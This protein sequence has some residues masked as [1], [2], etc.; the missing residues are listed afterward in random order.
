MASLSP[1]AR[2]ISD[3]PSGLLLEE[4]V[5]A[6]GT[7]Y[8]RQVTVGSPRRIS[9]S[10]WMVAMLFIFASAVEAVVRHREQPALI[11]VDAA[12]AL[13]FGCLVLRRVRP[14]LA[15]AIFAAGA[16][17]GTLTEVF[18]SPPAP[19]S[20][21]AVVPV[22][23][24][25]L[26]TYSLGA[27][28]TARELAIGSALPVLLVIAIDI[29][30][31]TSNS[32]PGALLFFF[33]FVVGAPALAGRLVRARADL[34]K[35]LK[36]QEE[37]LEQG[38]LARTGV[39]IALERV[40]LADRLHTILLAGITSLITGAERSEMGDADQANAVAAVEDQARSL[41]AETRR[42][43]VS[44]ASSGSEVLDGAA[45][46]AMDAEEPRPRRPIFRG[47][48]AL[49]WMAVAGA[50]VAIGLMWE[51]RGSHGLRVAMPIALVACLIVAM[52][53]FV[54]WTRPLI[55]LAAV[56]A[57]AALFTAIVV[58]LGPMFTALALLFLPA[59]AVAYF[60]T[61]RQAMLGLGICCLGAL[62]CF[63]S[64]RL[65]TDLPFIFG[66]WV[67]GR[68]LAERS[69]LVAQLQANNRRLAEQHVI[70]L[71][72]AVLEDR[73]RVARDL[74]DSVGHSLTVIALHAGAARRALDL[75]RAQALAALRTIRATAIAA[76]AELQIAGI[77][78]TSPS[79]NDVGR[80]IEGARAAGLTVE[81][82]VDEADVPLPQAIE[83][84]AYRVVQEALT[85][86]IR[87]A[88]GAT[89]KVTLRWAPPYLDLTVV[90][91]RS[92]SP[93]DES[94][95]GGR[96]LLGMRH[97]VESCGGQLELRSLVEG[98][99]E[100]RA[101]FPVAVQA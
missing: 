94:S 65:L 15:T 39:A 70:E 4:D 45:H 41:L 12:G 57:G 62:A 98:G 30:E 92:N 73:A 35:R 61:R 13:L 1:S 18:V 38:R 66:S 54:A 50:A 43:V 19:G 86:V 11:V 71:K 76:L 6:A 63:G 59:Y 36:D 44:I 48:I 68:V 75:D 74:H 2:P 56:W 95:P 24:L 79:L 21:D 77:G 60:A 33:V 27:Y 83:A 42:A 51:T 91:D 47:E 10:D 58:P 72:K 53:L 23:A 96:G 34:V 99:H 31:P 25:L 67:A 49:P 17:A 3:P 29:S 81:L 87:H 32:L 26:L 7:T 46:A 82:E 84:A 100:V 88:P 89:A 78:G 52:P 101:R 16:A 97:R 69:L 14:L 20:A 40:K 90:N 80:L 28:G 85:N 9:S 8:P 93:G 55:M 37:F 22:L 5:K 64:E